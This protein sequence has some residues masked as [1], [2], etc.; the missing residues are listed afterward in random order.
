MPLSYFNYAFYLIIW[1]RQLL[2]FAD[3]GHFYLTRI[4][5]LI[6]NF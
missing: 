4:L 2:F 1:Q 6:L 3:N 5:H